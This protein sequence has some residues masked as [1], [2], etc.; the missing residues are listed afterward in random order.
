MP[1]FFV[2]YDDVSKKVVDS[3]PT[4][5]DELSEVFRNKF[6][7]FPRTSDEMLLDFFIT[8]AKFQV[9]HKVEDYSELQEGCVIEAKF[10][11]P[12]SG[13][14]RRYEEINRNNNDTD[15]TEA[16]STSVKRRKSDV[17]DDSKHIVRVSGLPFEVTEQDIVNFFSGIEMSPNDPILICVNQQMRTTGEAFVR[18]QSDKDAEAALACDHKHIGRRYI[19][20]VASNEDEL[21][22]ARRLGLKWNPSGR[23]DSCN[24]PYSSSSEV[25]KVRGLPFSATEKQLLQFFASHDVPVLGVHMVQDARGRSTGEA[26]AEF[27]QED[28]WKVNL[29]IPTTLATLRN[30]LVTLNRRPWISTSK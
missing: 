15:E 26:F 24:G 25:L 2:K 12:R 23:T 29:D 13:G 19:E 14:R 21:N 1:T 9:L 18:F 27:S 8:D 10:M 30:H 3:I 20:V 16:K 7:D 28:H 6:E 11:K 5:F 17:E 22:A 4:D